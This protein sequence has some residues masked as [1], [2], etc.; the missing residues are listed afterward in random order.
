MKI[1]FISLL[2]A[3]AVLLSIA[4]CHRKSGAAS[5]N[6]AAEPSKPVVETPAAEP[7]EEAY[8][9]VAY[10][11]TACF[12]RCPVYQVQLYSDGKATW[13][14]RMNVSKLGNYE[15]RVSQEQLKA[16]RQKVHDVRFLDFENAYPTDGQRIVDLPVTITYIRIGDMDKTVKN[17]HGAPQSLKEFEKY[18]EAVFEGITWVPDS[19]NK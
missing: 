18:L 19:D 14:G 4:A 10:E 5:G 16:I 2:T 8:L 13:N 9:F 11:K 15:G 3:V 17:T 6:S 1:K 12:G 7:A